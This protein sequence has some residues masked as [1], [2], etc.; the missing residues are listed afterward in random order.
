MKLTRRAVGSLAV[1]SLVGLAGCSKGALTFKADAAVASTSGTEYEQTGKRKPTLTRE[2]AG[3]EVK[4]TN[5]LTEYQKEVDLALTGNAKLG[6][7]TAF[8]TPEVEVAGQTFNPIKGWSNQKIV[9]QLQSRYD[10]LNNVKQESEEEVEILGSARTV[11]KFSATTTYDGEE[12]PV[13]LLI[14]KFN[15]ESDFVVPMGV[16]PQKKEEEG[17][18]IKQLMGQMT[19][20]ADG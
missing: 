2:F 19:H 7:F 6:V 14:A 18:N 12:I 8:S 5:A 10:S 1:G 13:F 16:Y 3:K 17:A 9:E 4:V 11:T 20:P 15:H